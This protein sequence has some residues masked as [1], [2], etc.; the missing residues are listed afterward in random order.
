MWKK[1]NV[2]FNWNDISIQEL[3]AII[4]ETIWH[5]HISKVSFFSLL[6]DLTFILTHEWIYQLLLSLS[7]S[8]LCLPNHCCRRHLS[9][10]LRHRCELPS[11]T[12]IFINEFIDRIFFDWY[13]KTERFKSLR[14][15]KNG[16]FSC[17]LQNYREFN[18][19]AIKLKMLCCDRP[20]S[21]KFIDAVFTRI[22][23]SVS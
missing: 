5:W 15:C 23:L 7:S 18:R 14:V 13:K 12:M 8:V 21:T 10:Q 22:S 17:V 11:I 20:E 1:R 16:F 6:C 3:S 2:L 9:T 4:T 19:F